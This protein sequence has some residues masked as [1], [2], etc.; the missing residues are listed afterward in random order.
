MA[1]RRN[2][3]VEKPQIESKFLIYLAFLIILGALWLFLSIMGVDLG[4]LRVEGTDNLYILLGVAVLGLCAEVF[5][6]IRYTDAVFS[7][8]DKRPSP[9]R[10][11]PLL[12]IM[13]VFYPIYRIFSFVILAVGTLCTLAAFT[14][15]IS[16]FGV[17][18]LLQAPGV[19]AITAF[20]CYS[21]YFILRGIATLRIKSKVVQLHDRLGGEGASGTSLLRGLFYLLPIARTLPMLQDANFIRTVK[22]MRLESKKQDQGEY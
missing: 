6:D 22:I 11:V 3:P 20:T 18:F 21:L 8:V 4:F 19:F 14:P 2:R 7:F 10:Y 5:A 13:T 1:S 16:M 9:L 15:L 17:R 12:G